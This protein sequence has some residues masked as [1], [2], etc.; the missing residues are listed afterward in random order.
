MKKS[1]GQ[2]I[3][4]LYTDK[5]V[6]KSKKDTAKRKKNSKKQTQNN[7]VRTTLD[8]EIIIGLTPKQPET[9]KRTSN[10]KPQ[11]KKDRNKNKRK[12]SN[13]IT[14]NKSKKPNTKKKKNLKIIKWIT[15]IILF[16]VAVVLFMMSSLFNIKQI[17]VI[18]N[19]KISS[20]EIITLSEL[21][22]GINMFKITNKKIRDKIKSNAYI[23][24][25][26]I[27]RNLNGTVTLDVAERKA[28]YMLKLDKTYVYI[29]NQGYM[30]EISEKQLKVPL[31]TGF[32]TTNEE[33]QVGNRL[34]IE[35]LNRLEDVIK[36][37]ESSKNSPLANIIT[38]IDISNPSN[39]KLKIANE[40]KTVSFGEMVNINVKL[41]MVGTVIEAEKGKKG[42]IYFQ[43]GSTKAIFREEVSR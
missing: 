27:K 23:D 10:N 2:T 1:K 41:Q 9:K 18:N 30:L 5:K 3:D 6:K 42:E 38:G 14:K 20:D 16:I 35:D 26:K 31:I 11:K 21:K 29:N 32:S 43:D 36:I 39:Y 28:T 34:N 8:N 13:N 15:I 12:N 33:I 22:P 19:S 17:V 7:N 40:G 37:I 25:V 4:L 24:N